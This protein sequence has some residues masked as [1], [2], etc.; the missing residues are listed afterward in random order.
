MRPSRQAHSTRQ[1][2][3]RSCWW[4]RICEQTSL[5]ARILR[6]RQ[7]LA[8]TWVEQLSLSHPTGLRVLEVGC[9]AGATAVELAHRGHLVAALDRSPAM[10][11]RT[12]ALPIAV[13]VGLAAGG[14]WFDC[15]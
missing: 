5:E 2:E 13:I 9:G 8:L 15:G 4:D 11:G 7:Q 10:P 12:L 3:H 14:C 6:R 1:F